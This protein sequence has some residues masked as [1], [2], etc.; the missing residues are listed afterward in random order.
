M[1][2]HKS[3]GPA[4]VVGIVTEG[5]AIGIGMCAEKR[6][7]VISV[8]RI[9]HAITELEVEGC[10]GGHTVHLRTVDPCLDGLASIPALAHG[11]PGLCSCIIEGGKLGT[12]ALHHVIAEA[13]IAQVMQQ[14]ILVCLHDTLHIGRLM[15]EVAA[16]RPVFTRILAG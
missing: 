4:A 3:D 11:E 16:A 6:T 8:E 1:V 13:S 7:A 15:I 5:S 2:L 9:T 10:T 12:V 14:I